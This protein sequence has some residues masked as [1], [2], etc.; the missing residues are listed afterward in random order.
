MDLDVPVQ[1]TLYA[2]L[3]AGQSIWLDDLSR[4]WLHAGR[5]KQAVQAGLG[6]L[7]SNPTIFQQSIE[8]GDYD[9][10]VAA[11]PARSD[12]LG[13]FERL[14]IEDVRAAA[15]VFRG[16]Y[17][18]SDAE[19]GYV[20]FEVSPL[21]ARDTDAAVREARRL[22][23]A[24]ARPNAMIKIPGTREGWPA[25]EQLLYEGINVNITL[26]FSVQHYHE[27]AAYTRA[28]LPRTVARHRRKAPAPGAGMSSSSTGGGRF[29]PRRG[30][31]DK[32]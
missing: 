25:I 12:D 7:A 20:S 4:R 22:W 16:V 19:D 24:I 17:E 8:G 29:K 21:I 11:A 26:L 5:L 3:R 18:D 27:A 13:V 31:P 14:A 2:F 32:F 6:D 23:R 30:G 1:T 9:D 10:A 28:L 15:D